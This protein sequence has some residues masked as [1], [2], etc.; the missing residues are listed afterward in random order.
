MQARLKPPTPESLT[1]KK[2]AFEGLI[3][4]YQFIKPGEITV[5]K[6]TFCCRCEFRETE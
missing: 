2:S 3:E 1:G 4:S 6:H 5:D